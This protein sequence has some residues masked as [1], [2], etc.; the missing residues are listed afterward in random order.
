MDRHIEGHEGIEN[1][2][3]WNQ[4]KSKTGRINSNYGWM[5]FSPENGNK[6]AKKSQYDYALEQLISNSDTRQS[7]CFYNR[8]SM[9]WEWNDDDNAKHDFTCTFQTQ[10]FIRK[11]KLYYIINQRSCDCITGLIPD[12]AWHCY[13]YNKFIEDLKK[14]GKEIEVGKIYWNYGSVH[15]Y[16]RWFE[17]LQNAVEEFNG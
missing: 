15:C 9:Q 7:V 6:S 8:P 16:E 11:N 4:V 3:I 17:T 1:N 13:V 10:Q 2:P 14:A 12:F 5:V